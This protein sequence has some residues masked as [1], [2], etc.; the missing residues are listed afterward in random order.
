L[1]L[2]RDMTLSFRS[3]PEEDSPELNPDEYLNN[4]LK[5]SLS[6]KLH[7]RQWEKNAKAYMRSVQRR[8]EHIKD[9]FK[10]KPTRYAS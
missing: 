10:A 4:D 6:S 5:V 1:E 2:K 8:P 7:K 3:Y 9:L